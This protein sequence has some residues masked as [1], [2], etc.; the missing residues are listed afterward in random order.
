MKKI[1]FKK[2]NFLV[3]LA[4][5]VLVIV[6]LNIF[7]AEVR[8][9]F[10]WFSSPVQQ[11]F[12]QAGDKTAD[13]F[14]GVFSFA[15]LQSRLEELEQKNQGLI[16]EIIRLEELKKEN[17]SLRQALGVGLQEEHGLMT[18]KVI[19]KDMSDDVILIDKGLKNGVVQG[20]SVITEQKLLIGKVAEVFEKYSKIMLISHKEMSFDVKIKQEGKDIS[21]VAQGQGDS[22][23][24]LNL[25]PREQEIFQG[26]IVVTSSLG[27][28]F[29]ES[30]LVGTIKSFERS[31]VD[32]F[33]SARLE[34][35]FSASE[36]KTLFIIND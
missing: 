36:L 7:Q 19:S 3:L 18:A 6:L 13:F 15:C 28:V 27:G 20:M 12:W 2:N 34:N 32:P 16:A 35:S 33:Q 11:V 4:V 29:P 14:Q 30:F 5:P 24:D 17:D 25:I 21:A 23:V 9:F 10:Y 31:D 1:S 8:G 26:D 22:C